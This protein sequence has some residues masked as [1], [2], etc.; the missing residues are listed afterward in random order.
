MRDFQVSKFYPRRMRRHLRLVALV[1]PM[2]LVASNSYAAV[3]S[4]SACIK[5]GSKSVS[6]GK[7][8]T[9]VKSGKRLVWAKGATIL[10]ESKS[11]STQGL[12]FIETL[13]SP[14]INGK[15]PIE[16]VNFPIPVKLPSSWENLYENREGIAF[17]AWQSISLSGSAASSHPINLSLFV[18]PTTALPY[19]DIDS[20]IA[21]V[22]NTFKTATQPESITVIA[23]NFDDRD[24][25]LNKG[26]ELLSGELDF[27]RKNQE[28]RIEDMCS[29]NLK[30]CWSAM[31][32]RTPSGKSAIFLGVVE[33]AKL[34]T[35]DSSFSSYLRSANGLSIAHEYFHVLQQNI[36]GKNWFQMMF[37]PP[38]WFNEAS[39]V[40]VENSIMNRKSFNRYMQ[41]RAVD[42][43][44]AY[45]SCG[46]LQNGCI[47]VTEESLIKF[48]SLSNY[49]NNWSDF[50]YGMKYE[51]SNRVIEVL[52]SI[53]GYES[54]VDLYRY[55][56]QDH[57]FEE[58]FQHIFGI[59]YSQ[60]VP[61]LAKIVSEQFANN[62]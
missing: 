11:Q 24:W 7:S 27:Y 30:V 33:L 40:F 57:T 14:S 37:A 43:K 61:L 35:L 47:A 13:R 56:A 44:L 42:S 39:A 31:G 21:N 58:A 18:G 36:L 19:K 46:S 17:K 16:N 6:G 34:N 45:P 25:A 48:L 4:G 59:S 60:A 2:L 15:F 51:V 32:F 5:V 38:T 41:F 26:R 8:Y 54:L 3:K 9:C 23:F 49:S 53:K 62:R 52:V 28:S 50:P 55:Q 29:T 20:A 1:I 22:S 12:S 10:T